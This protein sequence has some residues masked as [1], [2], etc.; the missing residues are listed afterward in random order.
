MDGFLPTFIRRIQTPPT[1]GGLT[2]DRHSSKMGVPER[3]IV[4]LQDRPDTSYHIMVQVGENVR[5]GQKIGLMGKPPV[6]IYAHASTS[7]K[8]DHIGPMPH[9]LGFQAHSVSISSDG[10]EEQDD[11]T[12]LNSKGFG[13]NKQSLF[14]GFREMGVPLNYGLLYAQG[15]KISNLLINATEFEPYIISR[16]QMIKECC[17][18]LVDGLRVIIRACSA[19][20]VFI[21]IEKRRAPLVKLLRQATKEIPEAII[22]GVGRPYP[23]TA[24]GLLAKKLFAKKFAWGGVAGPKDTMAVDISSLLAIYNAW[25][26]GSPFTEQLITIA[27]SGIRDPQNTWVKIGTPL[28]HIIR[29][30][31]GSLSHLGRVSVGG[32]LMGIPQHSLE[33]PLIKKTKGLFAAVAFM[34]DEHRRSRFYKRAPCIKCAKCV[35]VCPASIIPNVIVDFIDNEHL[36][37]AEQWGVFHCVECGLCEYVCPSRIPLL[38]LIKLGK[39]SLKGEG[40]LLTRGN[41]ETLG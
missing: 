30:A 14:E 37:G 34:F 2:Q 26:L 23:E 35:D 32:P 38:E 28:T 36:N 6:S 25:F 17:Q 20:R 18:N 39:V 21:F 15:L 19:R 12:P 31:G 4:P 11:L 9:P 29:H 22:R 24:N 13:D 41:L 16:H 1:F 3:V 10:V 7:G 5:L 40:S 27:G 33:V 8:V